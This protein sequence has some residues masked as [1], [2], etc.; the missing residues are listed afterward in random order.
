M[1]R[2]AQPFRAAEKATPEQHQQQRQ[3]LYGDQQPDLEEQRLQQAV[4]Q[5]QHQLEQQRQLVQHLNS[6]RPPLT[7]H[8][9]KLKQRLQ[10]QGAVLARQ[11]T[12]LQQLLASTGFSD[13]AALVAALLPAHERQALQ[14]Q[15]QRCWMKPTPA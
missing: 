9:T 14:Q 6:S 7:T 10:Q 15:A 11:E 8:S 12:Q 13:E 2:A 4:E 1:A 3:Q 5:A